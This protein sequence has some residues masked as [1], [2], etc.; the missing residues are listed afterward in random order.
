M[1]DGLRNRKIELSNS[2]NWQ[3]LS[4]PVLYCRDKEPGGEGKCWLPS[5]ATQLYVPTLGSLD[6][7]GTTQLMPVFFRDSL[8]SKHTNPLRL[9]CQHNRWQAGSTSTTEHS[10]SKREE[11]RRSFIQYIKKEALPG[12][13]LAT[14]ASPV[15]LH[16]RTS[17]IAL[18]HW[19]A[20]VTGYCY[21]P[22][23]QQQPTDIPTC[24]STSFKC[25]WGSRL[26]DRVPCQLYTMCW[27]TD[28]GDQGLAVCFLH[29]IRLNYRSFYFYGY[30][31]SDC[32]YNPSVS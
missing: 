12:L 9:P 29:R 15:Q 6:Q 5:A 31:P 27:I 19:Q 10:T 21:R 13:S 2:L 22:G 18:P 3:G 8:H 16:S 20:A 14:N 25:G 4:P 32:K 28:S 7:S 23:C 24:P 1:R 17:L 26:K 30:F 11:H